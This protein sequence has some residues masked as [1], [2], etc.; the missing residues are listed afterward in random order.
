MPSVEIPTLRSEAEV[1]D[2]RL[3]ERLDAVIPAVMEREGIDAW[4]LTAREYN[5]DPVLLTM[6]PATWMS[7]RRRTILVFTDR[8]RNRAA[9]SRYAVGD[10]FP[11]IWDP[12][13]DD[14]WSCLASHL[15]AAD[16]ASIAVN[17]SPTTAFADGISA[18]EHA[19][20]VA[21][22]PAH[23]QERIVPADA[24]AV[25]WLETRIAEEVAAN[26]EACR[27][28]HEL[29]ARALSAEVIEPGATTTAD[30]A[31]W[32]RERVR[33]LG[34]LCWFHPGVSLQR[35][36][37]GAPES[38]AAA[39]EGR[40]VEVGD[41]VH[42]DFGLVYLGLHTDQ[43]QHGYVLRPGEDDAPEG[44]RTGLAAANRVQDLVLAEFATDKAGDAVLSAALVAGRAAALR[45]MIYSHPIGLHGHGAGPSIGLWDH[46]DGVPGTGP[47]PIHP[48]TA[49]SIELSAAVD[50]P[51]WGG[52]EVRIMVEEDAFFD[53]E[54]C[55]WL[56][57]RQE[58]LHLIGPPA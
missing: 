13:A 11:G 18:S 31:W 50:V 42:I 53:G 17:R 39:P 40:I 35:A 52:C 19:A 55:R 5:E 32:L 16:P 28:G 54:T 24:L 4:V 34:L 15:A 20:F 46:Q 8:G 22:L 51:E 6:L 26:G 49:W 23:L 10:A 1:R 44:L 36:G 41:L 57:G 45:P 21:A 33:D 43:Q 9:V 47:L 56:D 25:G 29:L 7:A 27:L 58:R 3:R 12:A 48:D 37:E 14:Q 2:R 30:V 38:F